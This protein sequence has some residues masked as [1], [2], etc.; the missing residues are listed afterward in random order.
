ME[1]IVE[2]VRIGEPA[3]ELWA[4]IGAFDAIGDWHPMLASVTLEGEGQDVSRRA[5]SHDGE[6]TV[7]RLLESAPER[8]SYR[9]RIVSTPAPVRD[10]AAEF[11]VEDNGDG[12]STVVWSAE[13][14][15]TVKDF[16]TTEIIRSFLKAGLAAIVDLHRPVLKFAVMSDRPQSH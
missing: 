3:G 11:R 5:R 6:L 13:F 2:T 15:P 14:E 16:Q 9:Y 1:N 12:T 4:K 8:R 7:E 10:Y